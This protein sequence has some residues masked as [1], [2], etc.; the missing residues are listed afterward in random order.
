MS[1]TSAVLLRTQSDERLVALARA[2]HERA[3]ETI[4]RRYRRPLLAACRR[5]VNDGRAE[6]VLQQALLSAWSGLRRGDD[7]RDLRAWLFRIMRNA[8][9]SH[10]R[11]AGHAGAQLVETLS[12]AASP[13]EEA[14]RR[15]VVQETL[16]TIA[17]LPP[18]QREALLRIAVQGASQDEVAE[19][20]GV[21]RIAVRQLVHRARTSVRAAA[22]A[23]LPFPLIGWAAGA[24]SGESLSLR[25]ASLITG[26]GSA[27]AA[28]T[29]AK[30]GVV[31]GVAATA[32]GAPALVEHRPPASRMV[33]A[34][35]AQ[36]HAPRPAA[37]PEPEAATVAVSTA[38]PAPRKAPPAPAA[39]RRH[40]A[41]VQVSQPGTSGRRV[42]SGAGPR[43]ASEHDDG[44]AS[45]PRDA[46]ERDEVELP[47]SGRTQGHQGDDDETTSGGGDE[48][49]SSTSG[50]GD[51]ERTA[52][53]GGDEGETSTS[54]GG[55]GERR[56][57][58]P[59]ATPTAQPAAT[60]DAAPSHDDGGSGG[61]SD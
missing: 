51:G 54:G 13:Q 40:R 21:S 29:F 3:F 34:R 8:A 17:A 20:L 46:A 60:D 42:S 49:E 59:G 55:E 39:S 53:G 48:G 57:V 27:G 26:A 52:S 30:A 23:L 37:T 25:I 5:M 7:V 44:A 58:A 41:V 9:L 32:V 31:A 24:G 11:R 16:E 36:T 35:P 1:R 2:G 14:E 15:E 61:D 50:G 6:D 10:R 43:R 12:M 19:D 45:K 33:Q 47:T 18:R 22:T 4:V 38:A 56:R 28:A